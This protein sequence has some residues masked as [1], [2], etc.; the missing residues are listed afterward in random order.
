VGMGALRTLEPGVVEV[1]RMFVRPE[2]RARGLG[3][4][5]VDR[6]L[7]EARQTLGAETIRLDT[8]RF[9]V[10]AQRLY[11]SRGFSERDPYP[12][13]EIPEPLQKYWKFYES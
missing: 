6:L 11:E 10:E 12:G 13:T 1:K 3:S 4:G 9:M 7:V 8:C 2:Y 5:I